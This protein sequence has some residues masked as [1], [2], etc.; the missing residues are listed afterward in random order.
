MQFACQWLTIL[1]SSGFRAVFD[2]S[3]WQV[4]GVEDC[5]WKGGFATVRGPELAPTQ[6]IRVISTKT[7]HRYRTTERIA[8][9]W[10]AERPI[11]LVNVHGINGSS[12]AEFHS[13][14]FN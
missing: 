6:C 2:G 7:G 8:T 5:R 11:A 13:K 1:K 10:A 9:E 12:R 4:E 14:P 3:M